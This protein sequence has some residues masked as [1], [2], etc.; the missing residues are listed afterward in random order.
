[1]NETTL[2]RQGVGLCNFDLPHVTD[3]EATHFPPMPQ[4]RVKALRERPDIDLEFMPREGCYT[5]DAMK[6]DDAATAQF[7]RSKDEGNDLLTHELSPW[8]LRR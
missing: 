7:F 2:S 1:L 6:V 8:L 5:V 3:N 4:A